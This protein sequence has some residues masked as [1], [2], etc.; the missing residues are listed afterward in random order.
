[1]GITF[2]PLVFSGLIN[3]PAA[4]AVTWKGSVPT[5]GV[6]PSSGNSVGDA[7]AVQDTGKIYVWSGS[8]EKWHDT[9]INTAAFGSTP[10]ADGYSIV[11]DDTDPF[12][13]KDTLVLQPADSTNP[14]AVSTGAQSFAGDKTFDDLVTASSGVETDSI[15]SITAGAGTLS[16]GTANAS[17][18]NI[19]DAGVNVNLYGNTFYQDVTNLEVTDKQITLNKDGAAASAFNSGIE[20]EEAGSIT[21]YVLTSGDRNSW[22]LKAPNQAGVATIS[23]GA[24][25]ITID[26]S[27]HDPVT[28]AAV[29]SAPNGGGATLTGQVLNLEPA[30]STNPGVVSTGTQNFA[31][32]KTF[33][34]DV[35]VVGSIDAQTGI[36]ATTGT[37]KLGLAN[38]TTVYLGDY[39]GG[40]TTSIEIAAPING[41]SYS[42]DNVGVLSNV[43]VFS[44]SPS[45]FDGVTA[46]IGT[47]P[48]SPSS[49]QA[50]IS[51]TETNPFDSQITYIS[52]GHLG[53]YAI[54]DVTVDSPTVNLGQIGG[55]TTAYGDV[56]LDS[57]N[58]D[59]GQ[60]GGTTDIIGTVT[61]EYNPADPTDWAPAPTHVIEAIDQL[62]DRFVEQDQV[63]KEPTGFPNRDDSLISFD[64]GTHT[65]SISPAIVGGSYD[66]YVK[67]QKFTKTGTESIAIP[68]PQSGGNYYFYFNSTGTLTISPV[69]NFNP[70]TILQESAFIA[71]VYWNS[72]TNT[73]TYFAEE[74]H[75]L[76][77][78]G[79][80]HAYLHTVFEIGRAH[81]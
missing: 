73:H 63:T 27:S 65:F 10:N 30:D 71:S 24:A 45:T 2:N 22:E 34:D 3:I 51:F 21:G 6:L 32:D 75:G 61:I 69:N 59:I 14:G 12:V 47:N 16:I 79:V 56:V 17:T 68:P 64:D 37:L 20:L 42:I 8:P 80:T 13:R 78:D 15:D 19:G 70:T 58:V 74:R 33:D 5:E 55:T 52:G 57:P 11:V 67:G 1:M 54:T 62:A 44:T 43:G 36:D 39:D 35:A 40:N 29:G 18:I 50:Y 4:G 26:Q 9:G 41:N 25:G 48:I 38:T 76:T 77:M 49:D 23:P 81:V 31:G 60:V 46:T 72:D 28:L 66:F 7:I 53:I